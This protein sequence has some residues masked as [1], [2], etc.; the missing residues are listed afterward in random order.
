M[1]ILITGAAGYLGS[2]LCRALLELGYKVIGIDN[3]LYD[4]Q[5]AVLPL[6]TNPDFQFFPIDVNQDEICSLLYR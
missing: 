2:S 6:L 4:N 5:Q 1:N 3:F